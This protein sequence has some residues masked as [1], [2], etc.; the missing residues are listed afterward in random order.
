MGPNIVSKNSNI[1]IYMYIG[2]CV[3]RRS[4]L[5]YPPVN[6]KEHMPSGERH[7]FTLAGTR[8]SPYEAQYDS[9]VKVTSTLFCTAVPFWGQTT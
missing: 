9:L 4:Y 2:L 6:S 3:Y 1:Y 8:C 5:V 7:G